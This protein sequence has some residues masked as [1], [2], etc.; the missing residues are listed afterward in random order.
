MS[1]GLLRLLGVLILATSLSDAETKTYFSP[2]D[3]TE[4]VML[5]L[6]ASA[7]KSILIA[8]YSFTSAPL[9]DILVKE[10]AAGVDVRLV[11]DKTEAGE[12]AEKVQL[13][14]LAAAGV[15]FEV[16][17]S[18]KHRAMHLKVMIVDE[19]SVMSGSYNF[20]TVARL[21]NNTFDITT[22][23]ARASRFTAVWKEIWDWMATP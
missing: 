17:T 18:Q 19:K 12:K 7:K 16:G 4:K 2:D 23:P 3:D 6:A 10:H 9:A 21:E 8:D 20:T 22:D 13:A 15:P 1:R 14:K 5:D 11:F